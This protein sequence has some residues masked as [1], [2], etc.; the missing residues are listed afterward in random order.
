MGFD[1]NARVPPDPKVAGWDRLEPIK[2]LFDVFAVLER[3]NSQ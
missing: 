3:Q 1:P 2:T